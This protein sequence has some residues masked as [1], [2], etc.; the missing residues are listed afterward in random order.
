MTI[1][2]SA[3]VNDYGMKVDFQGRAIVSASTEQEDR[4]INANSGKVWSIDLDG[5]TANAGV[6]IAWFQNTSQVFY[7]MTDMRSHCLDAASILDIDE[8]TVGTIGNETA[9][10]PAAVAS[11]NIG[12]SSV[13]LGSMDHT[14]SATGLTGLTKVGNMFHAGSLDN[15]SSHLSTTSNII[16]PPG[17]ALAVKLITA[18]A[19]NGVKITWSLVE[20]EHVD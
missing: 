13:P 11:R 16:V 1:I 19:T 2:K 10:L 8:V 5:V 3:G 18:N 9:F 6:Y 17:G 4:H 14:A 12:V 20:V 7:H 15:Q